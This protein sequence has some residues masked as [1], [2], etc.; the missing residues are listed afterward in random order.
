MAKRIIIN[1]DAGVPEDEAV[2]YVLAVMNQGRISGD[3]KH[4][5]YATS[6][7]KCMVWAREPY[8]S[9]TQTFDIYNH[10]ERSDDD[11]KT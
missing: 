5:C 4:W 8:A 1:N 11:E 6:F 7:A 10:P 2:T 9:G 3:G